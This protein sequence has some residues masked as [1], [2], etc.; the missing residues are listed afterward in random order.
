MGGLDQVIARSYPSQSPFGGGQYNSSEE[1]VIDGKQ[2]LLPTPDG[3]G[4]PYANCTD[5]TRTMER[6]K[7]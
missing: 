1:V 7:A 4:D 5:N 6:D 3:V 2:R